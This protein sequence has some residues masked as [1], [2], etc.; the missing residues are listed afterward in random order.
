MIRFFLIYIFL[1]IV[2]LP[3]GTVYKSKHDNGN[4]KEELS[5]IDGKYDGTSYWYFENGYLQS[6]KTYS[7]GK[8]NGWF[9]EYFSSGLL[10][11]EFFVVNGYRDGL[12]KEYY[13]NGSL[14]LVQ[15]FNKGALIK[16]V[17]F[18]EDPNYQAPPEA[19]SAGV[20]K[21]IKPSED[22]IC[23]L[24]HCPKPI[25]GMYSLYEKLIYPEQAKLYGLEGNVLLNAV[26]SPEGKAENISVLKGIGL[27]CNEAAIE[28][29]KNTRF[30]PAKDNEK[31]ISSEIT[32]TIK[33]K[34]DKNTLQKFKESQLTI[35]VADSLNK[36]TINLPIKS[37]PDSSA[38]LTDKIN[39]EIIT[40]PV[41][42]IECN[43]A[44]HPVP[45]KGFAEIIS[46]LDIPAHAKKN[47]LKGE[48][49]IETVI[50]DFGFVRDTKLIK[51]I[52]YGYDDAVEFAV[53]GTKFNP[54]KNPDKKE[55][56][57]TARVIIVVE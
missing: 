57:V 14:K 4:L 22:I 29:L 25:G 9:K 36:S 13:E 50:D 5:I 17:K 28:A 20:R 46:R 19:Y 40:K 30:V 42:R 12:H 51:G 49:I 27:G 18:T 41:S 33:F 34:L 8:A 37:K 3:Q 56:Q 43:A 53:I 21:N 39:K 54:A 24:E 16:S 15:T 45:E 38:K 52:G 55:I 6:E 35:A 11:E 47:N 7:K 31:Y 48:V 26:I 32:I 23:L 44:F 2:L 1:I 10:K